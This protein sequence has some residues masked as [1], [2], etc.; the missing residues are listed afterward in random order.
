MTQK[1]TS[2]TYYKSSCTVEKTEGQRKKNH[3]TKSQSVAH[4]ATIRYADTVLGDLFTHPITFAPA[5][6]W[7]VQHWTA[8]STLGILLVFSC[9]DQGNFS[10]TQISS[11]NF[12]TISLAIVCPQ[13]PTPPQCFS[14]GLILFLYLKV[15]SLD[16]QAGLYSHFHADFIVLSSLK[17]S[18]P[19]LTPCS[20]G[21]KFLSFFRSLDLL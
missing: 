15:I 12:L 7:Q 8:A 18:W 16:P 19:S 1:Q 3:C 6:P 11:C 10:K 2:M 14:S 13:V 17:W 4:N 5:W 21:G 9:Y 20:L